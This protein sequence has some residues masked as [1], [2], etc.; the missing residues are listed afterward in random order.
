MGVTEEKFQGFGGIDSA[1]VYPVAYR[2]VFVGLPGGLLF[3][4]MGV[5]RGIGVSCFEF[6]PRES[7]G[8]AAVRPSLVASYGHRAVYYST[9]PR[10]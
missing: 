5:E 8:T 2:Q 3:S 10:I 1:I 6:S 7:E 4:A 9:E